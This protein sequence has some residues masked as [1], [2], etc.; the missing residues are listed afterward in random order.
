MNKQEHDVLNSIWNLTLKEFQENTGKEKPDI[1]GGCVLLVSASFAISLILMSLEISRSK[2]KDVQ[3]K[4]LLTEKIEILRE[5]Q[6]QLKKGAD[7]DLEAFNR[8][9]SILQTEDC[10]EDE[11]KLALKDITS[12]PLK[13]AVF[14]RMGINMAN[15]CLSYCNKN[16][17]SDLR[18][19]IL[20]LKASY[21]GTL[22]LAEENINLL[23]PE[24]RTFYQQ[25]KEKEEH[26]NAGNLDD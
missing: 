1:T 8:Y 24:E 19:G 23:E 18:S 10:S 22:L 6:S 26:K 14:I 13:I 2:E 4:Q 21:K 15:D 17:L 16:V 9:R 11:L 12:S 7:Y 3:V 25:W 5:S 20:L